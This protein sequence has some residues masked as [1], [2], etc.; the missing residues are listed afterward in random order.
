M[1][2]VVGNGA[3]GLILKHQLYV[4][5]VSVFDERIGDNALTEFGLLVG[6]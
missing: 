5:E 6:E 1:P 2:T 3:T 4:L